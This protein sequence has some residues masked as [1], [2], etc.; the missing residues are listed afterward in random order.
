MEKIKNLI[1]K[2]KILLLIFLLALISRLAYISPWLTDWDSVQFALALHD[3]DIT[4]HQPHP[5]GYLLYILLGKAFYVLLQDDTKA[6][7]ALSVLTGSLT[8]IPVYLLTKKMF[9]KTTA[10]F[11]SILF[12]IIPVTWTLSEVA[13][14]NMP[15]LFFLTIFAYLLY[16]S[17]NNPK[18]IIAT[19]FLGGAI[20]GVRFT[21]VPIIV[22]LIGLMLIRQ[23][24]IKHSIYSLVAL[25]A[26]AT[27]WLLPLVFIT[28]TKNFLDSYLW[29][30]NYVIE[31]DALLEARLERLFYLLKVGYTPY[32][33]LL[34]FSTALWLIFN[35]ARARQLRYQFLGIWLLAYSIP[36]AVVYNL[37]VPR[38]TLPLAPPLVIITAVALWAGIKKTKILIPVFLFLVG[39][40][41]NQSLSQLT[42]L[43]DTTPPTIAAVLYVKN[44]FNP[45]NTAIGT[46][47]T[48]RHFKHYAPEFSA[49][50]GNALAQVDISAT[51]QVILDYSGLKDKIVGLENFNLSE[52]IEFVGDKDIF[53]RV[54][55]ITLYIYEKNKTIN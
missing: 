26:G 47:F 18:K 3:F 9:N 53:T 15:G 41:L 34:G 37:E 27:A 23:F 1:T 36:L 42:R 20:L 28:G 2:N 6:L 39:L 10:I 48:Y 33:A 49:F 29:I 46:S 50:W 44:N 8:T 4:K 11:A 25:V 38:Y 30:A 24:S 31:H 52:T 7:T 13:L 32:F 17:S 40:I 43:A 55:N 21:E 19:S 16:I 45:K 35:K 22:A 54:P 14:T 51:N 12:I 5:P